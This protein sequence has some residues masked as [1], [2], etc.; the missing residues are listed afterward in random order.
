[1]GRINQLT[2]TTTLTAN[3]VIAMDAESGGAT[4][5]VTIQ[6]LAAGL[7]SF[8]D[9]ATQAQLAAKQDVLTFDDA[10]EEDSDNPVTSGGIYNAIGSA[11]SN[12]YTKAETDNAIAQST[13][14]NDPALLTSFDASKRIVFT[15]ASGQSQDSYGGCWYGKIGTRVYLHIGMTGL[16][17]NA[18]PVTV[19]TLPAGY[20]P[21]ADMVCL[22]TG[23]ASYTSI[24]IMFVNTAGVVRVNSQDAYARIDMMFDALS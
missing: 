9:Y 11:M 16:T 4:N 24:A 6:T 10:P 22:G 2:P 18:A 13:A 17:A 21:I 12:V 15:P 14:I 3:S 8:G 23:G 5:K 7:R 1:M 20:R 19:F